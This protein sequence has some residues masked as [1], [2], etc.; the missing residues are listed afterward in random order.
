MSKKV[1]K[2]A[3][4]PFFSTK[5][6]GDGSGLGLSMVYGFVQQSGGHMT[7]DSER[8]KGTRVNLYLPRTTDTEILDEADETAVETPNGQETI[9]IVDDNAD[10]RNSAAA[11]I[12]RLGY[13]VLAASEG[14]E[15]LSVPR[16]LENP[17][18]V[19]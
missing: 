4:E 10:V 18:A 13:D 6:E 7:L 12:A 15:A 1:L 16:K 8:D 11:T 17:L 9:L 2:S 19:Q 5:E 3:I 14:M